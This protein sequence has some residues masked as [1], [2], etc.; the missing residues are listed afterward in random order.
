MLELSFDCRDE[1]EQP[2]QCRLILL[3]GLY[4]VVVVE[5]HIFFEDVER[6]ANLLV[7][8][9][10]LEP[11]QLIWL[12]YQAATAPEE[13]A[14]LGNFRLTDF[15]Y[16]GQKLIFEGWPYISQKLI[17][18]LL[19]SVLNHQEVAAAKPLPQSAATPAT[20]HKSF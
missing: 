18:A 11:E 17:V 10:K 5:P 2:T 3:F 20:S 14:Q 9:Y 8:E 12:E 19:E 13:N 7:A 1:T 15:R 16:N 4:P 6:L